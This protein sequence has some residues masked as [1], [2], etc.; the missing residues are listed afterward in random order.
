[1]NLE[2]WDSAGF[3]R[4]WADPLIVPVPETVYPPD[5]GFVLSV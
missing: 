5:N 3:F 1:M 2:I 4:P